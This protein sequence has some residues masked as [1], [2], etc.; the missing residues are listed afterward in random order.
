MIHA[1][2]IRLNPTSDQANYL[3]HA[4]GTSRFMFN[5]GLG[6][7]K[8]QT[9]ALRFCGKILGAWVTKTASWWVVSIQVA[10]ADKPVT[11]TSQTVGI[12][13]GINWLATLSNGSSNMPQAL[14]TLSPGAVIH[15]RYLVIDLLRAGGFSAV[16]LV[17]DQ[18]REDSLLALKEAIATQKKARER[19]AFESTLLNPLLHPALPS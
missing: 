15:G 19:F 18:Q 5:W 9:E 14:E 1:H 13:V 8:R 10:V 16:Y 2:K 17:Q 4:A 11:N 7:W 3:A 6:Q 12:H